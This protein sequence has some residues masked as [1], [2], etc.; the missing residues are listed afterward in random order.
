MGRCT[1]KVKKDWTKPF[2]QMSFCRYSLEGG[3]HYFVRY[4]KFLFNIIWTD[5]L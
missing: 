1:K 3:E 2:L 5:L 4:T